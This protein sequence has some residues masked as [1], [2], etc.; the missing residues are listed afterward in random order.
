V[1]EPFAGG[2]VPTRWYEIDTRVGA[3][4]LEIRRDTYMDEV[5]GEPTTGIDRVSAAATRF[6]QR[7]V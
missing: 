3:I 7:I 4:M 5:T 2:Y 6:L 1:N